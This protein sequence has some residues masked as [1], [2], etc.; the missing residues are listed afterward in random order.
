MQNYIRN[1]IISFGKIVFAI[2]KPNELENVCQYSK[3]IHPMRFYYSIERCEEIKYK[4]NYRLTH[5]SKREKL[6][7]ILCVFEFELRRTFGMRNR[8]S[9]SVWVFFRD[10]ISIE[11][12]KFVVCLFFE[13]LK[14]HPEGLLEQEEWKIN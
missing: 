6:G 14:T 4:F 13:F 8:K 9:M 5:R 1:F 12:E 10:L 7:R 11:I 3:E 2:A